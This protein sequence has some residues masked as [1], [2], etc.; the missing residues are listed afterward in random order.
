MAGLGGLPDG[1][2]VAWY[3]DDFTGSAATMEVLAF[4]GI[5]AVLFT[6]TPTPEQVARFPNAKGIGIA[7]TARSHGPAWMDANLSQAFD[8]LKGLGTRIVHYKVC[9]TLD[10]SPTVGSIGRAMEIGAH[11]I[12]GRWMPCLIA[13]PVMRRYQCFGN[14]FA[15]TTEGVFRLDR[16]PVMARHPVTPMD[17]ADV[18]RHLSRQTDLPIALLDVEALQDD[19]DAALEARIADG[20]RVV[21]LDTMTED[22][23]ATCGRLIW[24]TGDD[25]IFVVGSQGVEYALVAHWRKA[26]AVP[27][28]DRVASAGPVERM[29][30]VSGSVSPLTAVQISWAEANG[31]AIIPLDAA[32]IAR[33]DMQAEKTAHSAAVDALGRGLDPLICSARGPDDQ[34]VTRLRKTVETARLPEDETNNR[35]GAA[36]GRLLARLL[37]ESGLRR[38]VI[39]GG[40]TSGHATRQLGIYAFSALAPTTPGAALLKAHSEDPALDGLQLALKGGQMGSLDYFGWI[41]RGGGVAA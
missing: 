35:I 12:G 24:E 2:L 32:A 22:H 25:Q 6:G 16:H 36:L 38:A 27:P 7:S 33:G 20:A 40:D 23:L 11:R 3:G 41:K 21:C 34:A 19:P 31:F 9:S 17:E 4:A 1:R 37:R 39:S 18:A 10:S 29:I 13:A 28:I 5:E 14:L 26:G 8:F 15:G 30:A